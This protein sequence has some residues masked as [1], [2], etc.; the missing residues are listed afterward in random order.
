M[1]AL[2]NSSAVG[3]Q[4]NATDENSVKELIDVATT[5]SPEAKYSKNF[6][7]NIDSVYLFLRKGASACKA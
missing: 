3:C 5:G 6:I 2:A 4:R 7:G 1:K